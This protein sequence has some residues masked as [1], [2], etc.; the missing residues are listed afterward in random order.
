MRDEMPQHDGEQDDGVSFFDVV[1]ALARHRYFLVG[2]PLVGGVIAAIVSLLMTEIFTGV[3]KILP[4]QQPQSSASAL[5]GQLG[6]LA[7]STVGARTP[8]D[9]YIGMLRSRTVAEGL[10]KRFDLQAHYK[11]NLVSDAHAVLAGASR[12][13]AGK[14]GII[15]IEVDDKDRKIAADIANGYVSEL[16][17]MTGALAVTEAGQRRVFFER[18][19]EQARQNLRRAE[20][21]AGSGMDASGFAAVDA[22]GRSIAETSALLRARIASKEVEIES[23]QAFAAPDNPGYVRSKQE[24]QALRL[25]LT[26]Q[27]GGGGKSSSKGGE[28]GGLRNVSLL[29]DV[30]YHEFLFDMLVKQYE[31]ARI[32]EAKEGMVIQVLDKA[33]EADRRTSPKRTRIVLFTVFACGFLAILAIIVR[34]LVW[35]RLMDSGSHSRME[36]LWKELGLKGKAGN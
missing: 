26:K 9:L 24:L 27:E 18:Q 25:Q 34:E 11:T 30:K 29:R 14:D 16:V 32:D 33:I 28:E 2:F 5:L 21:A 35:R 4:P 12:I 23:M 1:L 3:T 36:F 19:L 22:R 15:S 7:G 6:G 13:A 8:I 10:I 17:R 31:S 20:I